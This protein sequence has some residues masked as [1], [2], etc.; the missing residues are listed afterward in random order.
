MGDEWTEFKRIVLRSAVRWTVGVGVIG[1]LF[2]LGR[3]Q[4]DAN[5]FALQCFGLFVI[6]AVLG[7]MQWARREAK[8]PLS[9]EQG[10]RR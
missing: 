5:R 6:G 4:F 2:S 9:G 3:R 7:V 8:A 10:R 1:L